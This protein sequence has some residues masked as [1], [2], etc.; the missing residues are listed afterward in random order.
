MSTR[1]LNPNRIALAI[2]FALTANTSI[3]ASSNEPTDKR[4][5]RLDSLARELE[6]GNRQALAD[7]IMVTAQ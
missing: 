5:P 3:P 7:A 6:A 4:S 2:A 1:Y